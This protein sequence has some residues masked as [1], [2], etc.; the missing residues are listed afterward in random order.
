MINFTLDTNP[1][2]I[3]IDAIDET[4][5]RIGGK[6][7]RQSLLLTTKQVQSWAPATFDLLDHDSLERLLERSADV[8][9]IGTGA[10]QRFPDTRL[11]APFYQRGLGVEVMHSAAAC[12]TF[13]ILAA[14][15]RTP[16][17]GIIFEAVAT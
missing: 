11:L 8:Y 4:G 15:G 2:G 3:S 17:A 14:E 1:D 16:V 9:L 13:N 5:I 10:T 12:K 6:I 7:H